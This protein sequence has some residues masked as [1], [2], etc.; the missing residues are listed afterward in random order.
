LRARLLQEMKKR[1][2]FTRRFLAS[3][4]DEQVV[5]RSC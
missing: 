1:T 4:R 5:V 2:W 3:A